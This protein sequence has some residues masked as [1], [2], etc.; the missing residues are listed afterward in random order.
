[1]I[2]ECIKKVNFIKSYKKNYKVII[3]LS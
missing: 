3:V 1:M 2:L